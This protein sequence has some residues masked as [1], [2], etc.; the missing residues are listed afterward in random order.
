MSNLYRVIE[1]VI[2]LVKLHHWIHLPYIEYL[3]QIGL[4]FFYH[5]LFNIVF[6]LPNL[7]YQVKYLALI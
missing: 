1:N 2:P 7:A 3:T 4:S 5:N 6:E